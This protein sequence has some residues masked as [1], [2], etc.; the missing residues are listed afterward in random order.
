MLFLLMAFLL[1]YVQL[2]LLMGY[3]NYIHYATFMAARAYLS[4]G[5]D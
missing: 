1:F 4:P 2:S 3:G 5:P